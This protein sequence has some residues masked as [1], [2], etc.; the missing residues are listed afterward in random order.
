MS[1]SVNLFVCRWLTCVV[2]SCRLIVDRSR[3]K[4][5]V[6]VTRDIKNADIC[7]LRQCGHNAL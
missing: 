3:A 4:M 2:I 6:G 5:K 1:S 7:S